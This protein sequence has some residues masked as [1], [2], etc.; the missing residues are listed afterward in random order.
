MKQKFDQKEDWELF[1]LGYLSMAKLGCEEMLKEKSDYDIEDL[2]ISTIYNFKH[3]IEIFLKT[4]VVI[5][6]ERKLIKHEE[7]HDQLETFKS[8]FKTIDKNK[9]DIINTIDKIEASDEVWEMIKLETGKMDN[10]TN[11]VLELIKKYQTVS[12]LKEKIEQDYL[13][14]D[15]VNDVFRYPQ[16]KMKIDLNYK[17]IIKR[18]GE[19]DILDLYKDVNTADEVFIKLLLIVRNYQFKKN[20][21]KK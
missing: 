1:F 8:F 2:Y 19:K 9:K 20:G 15:G 11:K 14:E 10:L 3:A 12:F 6:E 17:D 13:I 4:I 7:T 18:I 21:I 16:N 5:L